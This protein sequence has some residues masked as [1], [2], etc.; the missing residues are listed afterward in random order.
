M[1]NRVEAQERH[2][3]DG[4]YGTWMLAVGRVQGGGG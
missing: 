2:R 1:I 4:G 3:C